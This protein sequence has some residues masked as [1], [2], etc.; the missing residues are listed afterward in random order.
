MFLFNFFRSKP[1]PDPLEDQ[2][3]ALEYCDKAF[4]ERVQQM[5]LDDLINP[6]QDK[7]D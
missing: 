4:E 7:I 2:K 5:K 6:P 3:K 1:K